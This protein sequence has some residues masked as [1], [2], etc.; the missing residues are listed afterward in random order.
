MESHWFAL[1]ANTNWGLGG[2][3]VNEY[4][5]EKNEVFIYVL[6][7]QQVTDGFSFHPVKN[8]VLSLSRIVQNLYWDWWC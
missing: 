3:S 2:I 6:Q 4:A 8:K 7:N 1:D 5:H